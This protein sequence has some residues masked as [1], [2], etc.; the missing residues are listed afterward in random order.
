MLLRSRV[1]AAAPRRAASDALAGR[2]LLASM[3]ARRPSDL[4]REPTP[5]D[6]DTAEGAANRERLRQATR[7]LLAPLALRGMVRSMYLD[8]L[9]VRF[10]LHLPRE[11]VANRPL[12]RSIPDAVLLRSSKDGG[13][14]D[15]VYPA[16]ARHLSWA[17]RTLED[18]DESSPSGAA[19]MR[20]L[21][22]A[23]LSLLEYNC[24]GLRTDGLLRELRPYGHALEKET[25]Q[26][27]FGEGRFEGVARWDDAKYGHE[28]RLT[29]HSWLS[30]RDSLS[31]SR[32]KA[33]SRERL[34]AR[35]LPW[36][37]SYGHGADWADADVQPIVD[38][39]GADSVASASLDDAAALGATLDETDRVQGRA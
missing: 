35:F 30:E 20:Q 4:L 18:Y 12:L 11:L 23:T 17:T 8:M 16:Y 22:D 38:V 36:Y 3:Y 25:L 10:D 7:E 26:A 33:A 13:P 37:G 39:D 29:D 24:R 31:H 2:R 5:F 27:L 1:S 19:A 15:R 34:V 21:R 28:V 14:R 6:E 32:R 9:L